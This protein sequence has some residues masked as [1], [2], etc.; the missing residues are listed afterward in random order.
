MYAFLKKFSI[1]SANFCGWLLALLMAVIFMDILLRTAGHP[2]L[3]VAEMSTF[4]MLTTVY[5][6]MANCEYRREHVRVTFFLDRLPPRPARALNIACG[7]I[8]SLTLAV[9]TWSMFVNT[10]DSYAGDEAMA[11][12]VPIVVWPVKA[13]MTFGIGLY[14]LQ[15]VAN[16]LLA[17]H[18]PAP[19]P[20]G[21]A[22]DKRPGAKDASL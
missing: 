3:G 1:L 11:G 12:L 4:I 8:C 19:R 10:L 20:D 14:C 18:E 7:V 17:I 9:C 15:T 22:G 5:L 6:G 2:I 16:L 13:V 21:E